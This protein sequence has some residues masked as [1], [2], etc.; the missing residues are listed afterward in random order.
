M[1]ANCHFVRRDINSYRLCQLRDTNNLFLP[2]RTESVLDDDDIDP[3]RN[4]INFLNTTLSKY[5]VED[6]LFCEVRLA[7]HTY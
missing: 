6:Q 7:S 5:F 4:C 3:D 1:Y 2:L